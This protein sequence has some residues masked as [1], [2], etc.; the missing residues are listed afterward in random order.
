[1]KSL[2]N[3]VIDAVNQGILIEPFTTK[4]L[5][6]WISNSKI[7]NDKNGQDY[8]L[9]TIEA[10]LSSSVIDS[11]STKTDKKLILVSTNP[12]RYKII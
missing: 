11:A 10:F 5:K 1:M 8:A 6:D 2:L 12:N 9:S 7:T 3:K 4:N